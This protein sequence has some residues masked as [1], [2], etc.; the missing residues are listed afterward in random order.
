MEYRQTR[1][2]V[3][4]RRGHVKIVGDTNYIRVGIIGM[5]DRV[6]VCAVV[7]VR[8]PGFGRPINLLRNG[9][10]TATGISNS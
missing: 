2:D 5:K 1:R 4:T 6:F 10:A 8:Y 3:E 9:L 7:I